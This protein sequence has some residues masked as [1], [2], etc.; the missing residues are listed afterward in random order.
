MIDHVLA[1]ENEASARS[2]LPQFCSQDQEGAWSWDQSRCIP[3]IKIITAE[4]VYEGEGMERELVSPEEVLPG[5]WIAIAL[6][7]LSEELRDL[8]D[9]AC[10]LITNRS[11]GHLGFAEFCVW[12]SPTLDLEAIQAFR[13]APVFAGSNYPFFQ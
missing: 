1:F 6:P 3:N 8:P 13:V 4:A 5:F 7:E 2:A 12:A 11:K 9:N 10:R